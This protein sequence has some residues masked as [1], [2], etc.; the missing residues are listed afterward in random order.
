MNGQFL[1]QNAI[2]QTHCTPDTTPHSPYSI[3]YSTTYYVP[4]CI[5]AQC[6]VFDRADVVCAW[7]TR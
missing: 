3:L 2:H 4:L 5:L 7:A 6:W 1:P